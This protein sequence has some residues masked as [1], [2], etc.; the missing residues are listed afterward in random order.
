MSCK[1]MGLD[2]DDDDD[3]ARDNALHLRTDSLSSPD[4]KRGDSLALRMPMAGSLGRGFGQL[5]CLCPAPSADA[6]D[7]HTRPVQREQ[8]GGDSPGI[9]RRDGRD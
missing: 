8:N 9:K 3:A 6:Q 5:V 7:Y 4:A 2:D 1:R